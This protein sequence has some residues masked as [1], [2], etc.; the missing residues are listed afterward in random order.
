M[1]RTTTKRVSA[2]LLW[3]TIHAACD[4]WNIALQ[5]NGDIESVSETVE[6]QNYRTTIGDTDM[7]KKIRE[8]IDDLHNLLTAYQNGLIKYEL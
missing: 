1:R 2:A 4:F 5:D 7:G 8:E 3:F 6:L